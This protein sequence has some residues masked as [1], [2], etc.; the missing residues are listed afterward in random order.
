RHDSARWPAGGSSKAKTAL[1]IDRFLQLG[2]AGLQRI[3]A[4]SPQLTASFLH[5]NLDSPFAQAARVARRRRLAPLLLYL[6]W[7]RFEQLNYSKTWQ[8]AGKTLWGAPK[9]GGI[10]FNRFCLPNLPPVRGRMPRSAFL[11]R[12]ASFRAAFRAE[13]S[14]VLRPNSA[15]LGLLAEELPSAS[16]RRRRYVS[17][18]QS[19][20]GLGCHD[21]RTLK[22]TYNA[23]QHKADCRA[24]LHTA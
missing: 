22:T 23:S 15:W 21:A 18:C 9:F 7:G 5:K 3:F 1:G 17:D 19:E 8:N 24:S 6:A 20:L 2:R 13:F 11:S 4:K 12:G 16:Q 10:V 14:A